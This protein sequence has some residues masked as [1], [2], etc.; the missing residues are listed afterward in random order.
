MRRFAGRALS[1]GWVAVRA[2]VG[3]PLLLAAIVGAAGTGVAFGGMEALA[4]MESED[5]CSRCHTMAP[6]AEAHKFSSHSTV[7]C[8]ECHVGEGITGLVTAKLGGTR[9]MIKLLTGTYLK[10]IPPGAHAMPPASETCTRCHDPSRQRPNYLISRVHFA[11]D[12]LNSPQQFALVLRLAAGEGENATEGIHWHVQ[13]RVTYIGAHEAGHG[14]KVEVEGGPIA[15]DWVGVDKPDGTHEEFISQSALEQDGISGFANLR[16][17]ELKRSG[18]E[19]LMTCYDCHNRI[20]H[21][22]VN[23]SRAIDDALAI[24]RMD[25]RIPFIKKRALAVLEVK[26]VSLEEAQRAMSGLALYY[27]REYPNLALEEPEAL[28]RTFETLWELYGQAS[29]PAMDSGADDYPSYLGHR[30]SA[31]CFRCHDGGHYKIVDGKKTNEAIPSR[32]DTCHTFPTSGSGGVSLMVGAP[33]QTHTSNKLWVFD[34]KKLAPSD[35]PGGTS[36]GSCHTKSYC[37]SCHE[38]GATKISHDQML[39]R[40]ADVLRSAGQQACT[41]CHQRPFCARCHDKEVL[42]RVR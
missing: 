28:A 33:P 40:H 2:V 25:P 17:E 9:Q 37:Q 39:F 10:P 32:C 41:S 7:E 31:G 38:S 8:A 3:R 5:F 11:E 18:V 12:E 27:H 26:Y 24:G 16:V 6:Q 29:H 34:H 13:S 1:G 36:C 35:D 14:E 23:P 20:G 42:D 21:A 30:D 15:I 19:H 22:F 4:W